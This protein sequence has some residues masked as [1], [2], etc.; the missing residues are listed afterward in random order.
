[1][2]RHYNTL[3]PTGGGDLFESKITDNDCKM[4]FSLHVVEIATTT[5]SSF[6]NIFVLDTSSGV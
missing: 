3:A 2:A 5:T 1:M 4:A 6:L